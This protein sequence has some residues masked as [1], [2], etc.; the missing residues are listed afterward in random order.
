MQSNRFRALRSLAGKLKNTP[1][2]PQW[3]SYRQRMLKQWIRNI[4]DKCRVLD[5]GCN[6][7]WTRAFLKSNISYTGLDYF[8]DEGK[9]YDSHA[10]VF[11]DAQSLPFK[12]NSFDWVLLLDVLEHIPDANDAL[13]EIHRVL[14]ESGQLMVQIPFLYPIHDAPYDFRRLTIH[15]LE[16]ELSVHGFTIETQHGRG[17]PVETAALLFNI[18]VAGAV[19]RMMD[20]SLLLGCLMSL[21]AIPLVSVLNVLGWLSSKQRRTNEFMPFSY[22]F[23][24]RKRGI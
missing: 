20:K 13:K 11:G 15:G 1:L 4:E 19:A 6:D 18:A 23:V 7:R 24:A 3:L 10:D 17:A 2:H 9:L 22:Q 16:R 14:D 21:G 5:I 8:S 12:N